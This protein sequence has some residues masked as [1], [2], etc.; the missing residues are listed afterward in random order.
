MDTAEVKDQFAV[1]I[2]PH[3]VVAGELEDNV[4][5]PVVET[6][7]RLDKGC[8]HLHTEMVLRFRDRN[9]EQFFAVAGII[10]RN[11]IVINV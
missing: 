5:S 4:V 10:Q 1:H 6:I 3:V 9:R 2:Q 8:F 11:R 7:R